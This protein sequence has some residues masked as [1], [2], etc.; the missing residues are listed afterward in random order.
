MTIYV[1]SKLNPKY[2]EVRI[3]D[4]YGMSFKSCLHIVEDLV[5]KFNAK[6]YK[7]T[8]TWNGQNGK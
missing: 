5:N 7:I 8:V 2:I 3:Y 4:V 1:P 6:N